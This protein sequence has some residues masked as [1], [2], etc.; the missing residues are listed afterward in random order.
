MYRIITVPPK[1]GSFD[2]RVALA[3]AWRGKRQDDLNQVSGLTD[4]EFVH[5]SGFIG[6]AWSLK[7]VI[8]MAE[9][10]I[11]EHEEKNKT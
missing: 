1:L 6:G 7:S 8:A 11:K 4:G 2:M 5:K 10:S 3:E 9:M